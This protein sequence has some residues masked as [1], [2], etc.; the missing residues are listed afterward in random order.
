[1]ILYHFTSLYNLHNVGTENIMA[2]GLKAMPPDDLV[3]VVGF[4]FRCVWLT[5]NPD[6]P[7]N[8]SS[9]REV[10]IT[11]VVPSNSRKL[12]YWPK[13]LKKRIG[14]ERFGAID[15]Y[16]TEYHK[17]YVHLGHIPLGCFRAVE[18]ADAALREK[19]AT[20]APDDNESLFY[21]EHRDT[22]GPFEGKDSRTKQLDCG[23]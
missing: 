2:V 16:T 3:E 21:A 22:E 20:K 23:T 18:Y 17:W 8:H 5:S 15:A 14:K 1:M 13:I 4:D 7:P 10:R 11:L 19:M 9:A 6:H 12:I